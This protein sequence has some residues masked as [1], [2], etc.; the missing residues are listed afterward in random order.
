MTEC[1]EH[2]LRLEGPGR[3][4]LVARFDGGRTSSDGGVLLLQATEQRTRI[5][6][7]ARAP[8]GW[9]RRTRTP[10]P[11]ASADPPSNARAREKCGL[12]TAR[13]ERAALRMEVVG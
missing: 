1:S 7:L 5:V 12:G 13:Y 6:A 4:S 10:K 9:I 2:E 8:P 11:R 3:R